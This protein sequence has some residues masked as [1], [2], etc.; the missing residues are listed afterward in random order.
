M[1]EYTA[2]ESDSQHYSTSGTSGY[3]SS[4]TEVCSPDTD[5]QSLPDEKL[6]RKLT[7]LFRL[8]DP[9]G[10]AEES[11]DLSSYSQT[12]NNTLH[13]VEIPQRELDRFTNWR[14]HQ[15][16][17]A[18]Q[19]LN[20]R[21]VIFN[22]DGKSTKNDKSL[23]CSRRQNGPI[24]QSG[25]KRYN[26]HPGVCS[27]YK[28]QSS[29]SLVPNQDSLSSPTCVGVFRTA[30]TEKGHGVKITDAALDSLHNLEEAAC[31][32]R[33]NHSNSRGVQSVSHEAFIGG[34][35][36]G[37]HSKQIGWQDMG[38]S[39]QSLER[40]DYRLPVRDV[41]SGK[42]Y[43]CAVENNEGIFRNKRMPSFLY[44]RQGNKAHLLSQRKIAVKAKD[45][46]IQKP[47]EFS[48]NAK[49]GS[50]LPTFHSM[51]IGKTPQGRNESALAQTSAKTRTQSLH[52]THD[53]TTSSQPAF[54]ITLYS[55]GVQ[56][57]YSGA[58]SGGMYDPTSELRS[59]YYTISKISR[60]NAPLRNSTA[61]VNECV[62]SKTALYGSSKMLHSRKYKS[63]PSHIQFLY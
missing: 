27:N 41:I 34:C 21:I 60:G 7:L 61:K 12:S 15:Q 30:V 50:L 17:E 45:F 2:K 20:S 62:D 58:S 53:S 8:P 38:N 54:S 47:G 18:R 49:R 46:S 43:R 39:A 26:T 33:N 4:G 51:A 52:I 22:K 48:E 28:A 25:M 11:A 10:N 44:D 40:F 16:P 59:S 32:Q 5:E 6:K 55:P 63:C 35:Q 37:S 23:N 24:P 19:V 57:T 9:S 1:D 14:N 36:P 3:H 56:E 29:S 13:N 31:V 42:F